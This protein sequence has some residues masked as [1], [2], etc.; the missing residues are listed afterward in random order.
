MPKPI[1]IIQR[2]LSPGELRQQE[3]L[4]A[5]YDKKMSKLKRKSQ[6]EFLLKS[7]DRFGNALDTV[8]HVKKEF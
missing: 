3:A 2:P 6:M 4:R 8:K 5:R 1:K 7:T